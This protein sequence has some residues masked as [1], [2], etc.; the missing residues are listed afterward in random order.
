MKKYFGLFLIG[1]LFLIEGCSSLFTG[2][3][4]F[5][6]VR[7][8]QFEYDGKPYYFAGTNMWYGAY[9]GSP[10]AT[11]DRERLIRELDKLNSLGL[12]NIRVCA[13][14]ENSKMNKAIKPAIQISPGIYDEEI[15][16]GLDFLLYEMGKRNM[17]AV[18]YLNNYWQWSGGMAQY[19]EWAGEGH[20]P[21]PDNPDEG[22][23]PFMLYS[24]KFYRNEK[25]K[26]YFLDYVKMIV[27]RKNKFNGKF[28]FEDTAIMAW[29]L[30]NEPRPG[31]GEESLQ[32]IDYYYKWIDETA[33]YIHKLDPNHLVTTGN[34]GLAGSIGNAEV[35]LKSHESKNIDYVTIH[36]WIKNWGWFNANKIEET[37]K[38]AETKAVDYINKH[39][40]F[41]RKLNKPLT[42]EEFGAPRDN[43]NRKAGSPTTARD[44]YYKKVFEIV[45][46]SASSGAPIAG[47]NFWAWGGEAR[48][49]SSDAIWRSG[50]PL[51]G[52]PPQEEQGLNSVFDTDNSTIE[53]LKTHADDM[54]KLRG[55][56]FFSG[57]NN[58]QFSSAR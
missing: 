31:R 56:D 2:E 18:L 57:K 53:I 32:Y 37:Y 51:M 26:E 30:A 21:D 5:V 43:E 50:D 45:R 13:A 35:F 47:T 40:E 14:S 3:P 52:D 27:T 33:A 6:H 49:G 28:Y 48:A 39:I 16:E 24:G 54:L 58:P 4:K 34:E 25:A 44:M 55:I 10:G 11:G 46:D 22:Y 1:L 41:A 9:L 15:L 20:I 8:T 29:E 38:S 42:M 23:S 36:L 19:N 12:T 17:H 7:G